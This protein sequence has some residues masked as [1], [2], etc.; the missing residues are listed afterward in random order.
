MIETAK[1]VDPAIPARKRFVKASTYLKS[2]LVELNPEAANLDFTDLEVT[3]DH[4]Q[5][6]LSLALKENHVNRYVLAQPIELSYSEIDFN[7]LITETLD[8]AQT[9]S[10]HQKDDVIAALPAGL[11]TSY[12]ESKGELTVTVD[13]TASKVAFTEEDAT[14][15]TV[16]F[17]DASFVFNFVEDAVDIDSKF[18]VK[19]ITVVLADLVEAIPAEATQPTV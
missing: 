12:D 11:S 17:Q 19:D 13:A 3:V 1:F 18:T 14:L 10:K 4:A 6:K 5:R 9:Y 16:L 8:F 2:K 15:V 7:K